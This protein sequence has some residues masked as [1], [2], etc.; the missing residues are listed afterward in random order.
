M[1]QRRLSDISWIIHFDDETTFS[2]ADGAPHEAPRDGVQIVQ[3]ADPAIG[4]M[5][6]HSSDFYC[7]QD[8]E[9][10]PR[11]LLGLMDYL[12]EPGAEKT[13][14]QGR[15]VAYRRF[16]A[17]YDLALADPRLQFKTG[18]DPREPGEPA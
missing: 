1:G 6:W 12:R 4:R 17:I 18:R 16:R 5:I 7:W 14:L 3:T 15:G 13:V 9:W 11:S 2:S 10:V 8:G